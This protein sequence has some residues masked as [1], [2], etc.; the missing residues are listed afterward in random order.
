MT[1]VDLLGWVAGSLGLSVG[2]LEE[3]LRSGYR[4]VLAPTF[5]GGVSVRLLPARLP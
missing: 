2:Q 3:R 4:L 5:S 1:G